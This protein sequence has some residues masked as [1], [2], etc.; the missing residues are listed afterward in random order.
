MARRSYRMEKRAEAAEETRRRIVEACFALHARQGI[1]ATTMSQIAET[2]GVSIGTVYHHFPSYDDAIAACGAFTEALVP[3]PKPEVL[4]G[5]DDS[6]ARLAALA[7]AIFSF[8]ERLQCYARIRAERDRYEPVARFVTREVENRRALTRAALKPCG[9]NERTVKLT[10]ALLDVAVYDEL[11]EA[12]FSTT[13]AALSVAATLTAG[14]EARQ[15][16]A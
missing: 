7:T 2:A 6:A 14:L 3:L 9:A 1:A 11:R 16:A 5:C 13:A 12:G 15:G 8:Y 4:D 10:A